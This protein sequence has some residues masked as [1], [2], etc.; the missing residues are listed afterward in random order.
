MVSSVYTGTYKLTMGVVCKSS[1]SW[2]IDTNGRGDTCVQG[3][4]FVVGRDGMV[5]SVYTGTYKITMGVVC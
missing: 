2:T 5:S 1:H 4:V 3:N